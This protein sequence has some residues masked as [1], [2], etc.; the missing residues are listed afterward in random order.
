L[1]ALLLN[2]CVAPFSPNN[3]FVDFINGKPY[4][5]PYNANYWY[6]NRDGDSAAFLYRACGDPNKILYVEKKTYQE[7]SKKGDVPVNSVKPYFANRLA[8]RIAPMSEQE[9]QYKMH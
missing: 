9:L 5:I 2:G 3:T 8:G 7:L 6:A 1:S 4:A